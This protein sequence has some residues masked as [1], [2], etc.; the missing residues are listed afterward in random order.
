MS[1]QSLL[2]AS[3]VEQIPP[4]L[5]LA[6]DV[7]VRGKSKVV[8]DLQLDLPRPEPRVSRTERR[9]RKWAEFWYSKNFKRLSDNISWTFFIDLE[10]NFVNSHLIHALGA[11]SWQQN[12]N[13]AIYKIVENIKHWRKF[14]R[15]CENWREAKRNN[16]ELDIPAPEF[17][18]GCYYYKCNEIVY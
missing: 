2:F 10:L 12:P 18:P 17:E 8:E 5:P 14:L 1:E 7:I 9:F 16:P 13:S 3:V 6:R 11:Y 15:D 4:S